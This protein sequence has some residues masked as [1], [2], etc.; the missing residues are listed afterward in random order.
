LGAFSPP[1]GN[2]KNNHTNADKTVSNI[3]GG[4]MIIF[5]INIQEIHHIPLIEPVDNISQG[6]PDNK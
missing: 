4:P 1:D 5:D 3:K 2:D 6:P